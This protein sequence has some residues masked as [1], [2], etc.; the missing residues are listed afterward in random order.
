MK[1]LLCLGL[2][3]FLLGCQGPS[4]TSAVSVRTAPIQRGKMGSLLISTGEVRARRRAVLAS[5]DGGMITRLEVSEGDRV[6]Q[7]QPLIY[8]GVQRRETQVDVQRARR[9]QARARLA[10]SQSQ[11]LSAQKQHQHKVEQSKQSLVQAGISVS[12]A[13]LEVD[14]SYRDWQRKAQLLTEKSISQ[15]EVEQ[16]ELQWKIKK[17]ELQQSLSQQRNAQSAARGVRDGSVDLRTSVQQVAEARSALS[18]AEANLVDAQRQETETVIRAP[19]SGLVSSLK[20]VAGQTVG[21]DALGTVIDTSDMDIMATLDPA[22]MQG[23][24]SHTPVTLHSPLLG[25]EHGKQ[26]R[27]MELVPAVEGKG[28]TV[29]ARFRFVGRPD[30]RLVDGLNVQVRLQMPEKEGWLVP[31]DAV[32]E[33][34]IRRSRIRVVRNDEEVPVPV[35]V[36][37]QDESHTLVEGVLF[38]TDQVVIAGLDMAPGTRVGPP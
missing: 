24:D 12:Q 5:P 22:Q 18:E 21:S 35:V 13:R 29:R 4:A 15:S 28:N 38:E 19:I 37:A 11:L 32:G 7:G 31:R 36:V 16:A 34:Q 1:R 10:Q 30:P 8:L 33:D 9:D 25:N 3:L 6:F 17:D 20:V 27:F 2:G 14:A 23:L 26:L